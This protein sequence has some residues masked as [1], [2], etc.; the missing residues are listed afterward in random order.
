MNRFQVATHNAMTLS[1]TDMT[2]RLNAPTRKERCAELAKLYPQKS[3]HALAALICLEYGMIEECELHQQ[4]PEI[5]A[6]GE[7]LNLS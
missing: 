1:V 6:Y 7:H 3:I 4:F 2:Q 5:A